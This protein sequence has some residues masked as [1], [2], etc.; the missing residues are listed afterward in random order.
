M[1]PKGCQVNRRKD[2]I[3]RFSALGFSAL[4]LSW[5]FYLTPGWTQTKPLVRISIASGG[6]GGIYYILGGGM[7]ALVSEYI[8][9]VEA[10]G[11]VTAASVDN[12][13]LIMARKAE[14][15]FAGV[16]SVYDAYMGIGPFKSTGKMPLRTLA[17]LYPAVSQIVTVE[18]AAINTVQDLKGKRVSTAAPGSGTETIALRILEAVGLD[19]R[20]DIRRERLS[21]AESGGAIKD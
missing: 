4:A 13:K 1:K 9:G 2:G 12:C 6:T 7:A 15:A 3:L 16:D 20:K 18:G 10:T 5:L 21:V 17:A 11:E 19:P 8:P 14:V